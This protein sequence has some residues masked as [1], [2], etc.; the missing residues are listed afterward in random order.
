ML[1]AAFRHRGRLCHPDQN[2]KDQSDD[3]S[4][5]RIGRVRSSVPSKKHIFDRIDRKPNATLELRIGDPSRLARP[6]ASGINLAV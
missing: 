5:A 1:P 6:V 2:A 3:A 4:F